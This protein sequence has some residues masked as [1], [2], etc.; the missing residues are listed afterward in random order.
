[1][2]LQFISLVQHGFEGFNDEQSFVNKQGFDKED[3]V[4][5]QSSDE[6]DNTDDK[7]DSDSLNENSQDSNNLLI[8]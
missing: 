8:I 3:F 7:W 2:L 6:E 5:G 4:N 1:M